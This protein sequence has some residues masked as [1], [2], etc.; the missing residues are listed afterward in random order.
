MF[1]K[2]IC[3]QSSPYRVSIYTKASQIP[4]D[5]HV[6]IPQS[7]YLQLANLEL[8]EQMHLPDLSYV[9][10]LIYYHH[11]AVAAACFQ[12]LPLQEKHFALHKLPTLQR[13][14]IKMLLTISKPKLMVA[15]HLFRHDIQSFYALPE[16]SP[17]ECFQCYVKAIAEAQRKFCLSFTVVKDMPQAL[18]PYFQNHAKYF[19][20]LRN[21]V[22]MQLHIPDAWKDIHHYEQSLKHKYAQRFRNI[23]NTWKQLQVKEL[24]VQET[25]A[26]AN[27]LYQ[28][29]EQVYQNQTVRLGKLNAAFLPMLK[30]HFPDTLRIWLITEE[31]NPVAF[32]S[33]WDREDQFDMFYI[34]LD[35]HKN[36]ALHLYFNILFFGLEL[37]I[38]MRKK[39]L[40]LGRTALEAKARIGCEPVYLSTYLYIKNFIIRNLVPIL[41][42]TYHTEE[43]WEQRH[44]FKKT[45]QVK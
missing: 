35:Y 31:N 19:F 29:Y 12:I 36:N 43:S 15:G 8:H 17:Y 2:K 39:K 45:G 25:H 10:A 14:G 38:A 13:W 30:Q 16:L 34:G 20:P 7:H 44:P 4:A 41:I 18:V 40:I 23:R 3:S 26:C 21:D 22:S 27:I 11:Q 33:A 6:L 5:W 37:A 24:S 42:S 1:M 9:Y 32:F 28:L